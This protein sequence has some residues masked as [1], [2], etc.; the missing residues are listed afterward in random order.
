MKHIIKALIITSAALSLLS[1]VKEVDAPVPN[2]RPQEQPE[3]PALCDT[4]FRGVIDA[5]NGAWVPQAEV[6]VYDGVSDQPLIYTVG[7]EGIDGSVALNGQVYDNSDLYFAL[8]PADGFMSFEDGVAQVAVPAQQTLAD[9]QASKAHAISPAAAFTTGNRFEFSSLACYLKINLTAANVKSISFKGVADE[10]LAGTYK[11]TA[12]QPDVVD[13]EGTETEI[14]FSAASE[15]FARGL[16]YIQ[17]MPGSYQGIEMVLTYADNSTYSGN[18]Y[19]EPFEIT[20]GEIQEVGRLVDENLVAPSI[21]VSKVAFSSAWVSWS[22]S[23]ATLSYNIYVDGQKV[24]EQIDPKTAGYALTE[25]DLAST[26]TVAVEAVGES[27]TMMSETV[28]FTTKNLWYVDSGRH[29]FTIQW[30]E[31]NPYPVTGSFSGFG[32]EDKDTFGGRGYE[33]AVYTDAACTE[34]VYS[35]YPYSGSSYVFGNSSWYGKVGGANMMVPTRL[36][37]GYLEQNTTYYV[38]VRSVSGVTLGSNTLMNIAGTSEWSKP[39]E[40]K[41]LP[42]HTPE[43][44]EVIFA[45]FDEFSWN[46]DRKNGCPGTLVSDK[47]YT[48]SVDGKEI[49]TVPMGD[50]SDVHLVDYYSLI[51]QGTSGTDYFTGATFNAN[52]SARKNYVALPGSEVEGWHFSDNIRANMACLMM[53]RAQNRFIGTPSLSTNLKDGEPTAC[54]LTL[55]MGA[56]YTSAQSYPVMVRVYR[57][58]ALNTVKSITLNSMFKQATPTKD[59]YQ[60]DFST[61][62]YQVPL[63]LQKGDAVLL[64][65]EGIGTCNLMITVDNFKIVVDPDSPLNGNGSLEIPDWGS[66]NDGLEF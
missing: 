64:V 57:D 49:L 31:T 51:Q 60:L 53:D 12:Y 35:L 41:T 61:D 38:R 45:D 63:L 13:V 15:T 11:S 59:D 16:Y 7:D 30:E 32:T 27:T 2:E 25:F 9:P 3:A 66:D 33:V 43:A 52:K 36:S 26:H 37:L 56:V 29:H 4:E 23:S 46:V 42:A 8:Y 28:T 24:A 48:G 39:L 1:C 17:I 34:E 50:M 22:A 6:A 55:D 65:V 20:M 40:V 5:V 21:S 47:M 54:L 10:N 58:G 18:K 62:S 14:I 44:G 19:L